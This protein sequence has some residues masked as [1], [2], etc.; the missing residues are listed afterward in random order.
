M[1]FTKKSDNGIVNKWRH[2]ILDNIW[3]PPLIVTRFTTKAFVLSSQYFRT[4]LLMTVTS[5][6]DNPSVSY[7]QAEQEPRRYAFIAAIGSLWNIFE[8]LTVLTIESGL[9]V[10]QTIKLL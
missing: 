8:S 10:G 4:P 1:V 7:F 3:P 9:K 5:F 2:V 6:M